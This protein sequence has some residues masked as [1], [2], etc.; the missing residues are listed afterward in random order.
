MNQSGRK[1]QRFSNPLI[2]HPD[3]IK[4][5]PNL[6]QNIS[7]IVDT[8]LAIQSDQP[9]DLIGQ[10]ATPAELVVPTLPH[11]NTVDQT[12]PTQ[13]LQDHTHPSIAASRPRQTVRP[14][15]RLIEEV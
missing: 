10:P 14:P 12:L 15:K 13:C 2:G 9:E 8:C 4:C 3:V 7:E 6:E 1:P 5:R 11:T